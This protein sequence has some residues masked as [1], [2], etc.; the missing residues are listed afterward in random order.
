MPDS[1]LTN[2]N[3]GQQ[4]HSATLS[5]P[6]LPPL[7]LHSPIGER[8]NLSPYIS[9]TYVILVGTLFAMGI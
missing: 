7:Q 8:P 5:A 4:A 9:T 1:Q 6:P 3:I 2:R